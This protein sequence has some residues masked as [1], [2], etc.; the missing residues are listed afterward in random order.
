MQEFVDSLV[1]QGLLPGGV[2][3]WAYYLGAM[4]VFGGIVVF[5]FILPIAGITTLVERRRAWPRP[6]IRRPEPPRAAGPPAPC[7]RRPTPRVRGG[8]SA[9]R[10]R[11]TRV[12]AS[13]SAC[14]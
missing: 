4:L 7:G 5:V 8:Q 2:P 6:Q 10:R 11:S 3:L 9:A 12:P 13:R 14:G 1:A